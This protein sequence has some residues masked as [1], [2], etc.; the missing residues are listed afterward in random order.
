MEALRPRPALLLALP[1]GLLVACAAP[2]HPSEGQAGA[3]TSSVGSRAGSYALA[4]SA[5]DLERLVAEDLQADAPRRALDGLE[6]F[7]ADNMQHRTTAR[8]RLIWE[9]VRPVTM[10]QF[11]GG[12][13]EMTA[14]R[15]LEDML[16]RAAEAEVRSAFESLRR[17]DIETA[18]ALR[19]DPMGVFHPDTAALSAEIRPY[20]ALADGLVRYR[21]L[22]LRGDAS[23]AEVQAVLDVL[24]A[25]QSELS[26][27]GDGEASFLADA[28]AAQSLERAGQLDAAAEFWMRIA[29]S[30]RFAQQPELMRNLV[31]ARVKS[32]SVRLK[33][34]LI[35][36]VEDERRREIRSLSEQYEGRVAGVERT[37][38]DFADWARSGM[39]T[40]NARL[41]SLGS[42]DAAL[43]DELARAARAS[44]ERDD[45]LQRAVAGLGEGFAGLDRQMAAFAELTAAQRA[46]LERLA[47]LS[48]DQRAQVE[49]LANMAEA[50][51]EEL[52][53]QKG[54]SETQRAELERLRSAAE[55]RREALE[56]VDERV[57]S[58][59]GRVAAAE[60]E[61]DRVSGDVAR[62]E[63]SVADVGAEADARNAANEVALDQARA[64][65]AA[66]RSALDELTAGASLDAM[67]AL[68]VAPAGE[69]TAAAE[70]P[71]PERRRLLERLQLDALPDL[72][73]ALARA[74]GDAA[75]AVGALI[76]PNE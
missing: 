51:R 54:V 63:R 59:E 7:V 1:L 43:R 73:G 36:E 76:V 13:A 15:S 10:L 49:A 44:A 11:G 74:D 26:Q 75:P 35:I 4:S 12:R 5:A 56:S 3:P 21:D 65:L 32:H 52:Y 53:R 17:G 72:F 61:L 66:Y 69:T 46:E 41:A 48:E 20:A 33:E 60:G 40:A 9:A 18:R 45:E 47:A 14:A 37:H 39:A 31:A 23:D 8:A 55:L 38:A 2:R 62:V 34:R 58:V 64:D 22:A 29:A 42:E 71:A 70:A 27:L 67:M 19:D 16:V 68:V 6:A 28:A 50:Q 25:A 30:P 57:G 24:T